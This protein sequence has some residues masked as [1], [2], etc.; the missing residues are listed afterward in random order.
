[1]PAAATAAAAAAATGAG[2]AAAGA[3]PRGRGR[4]PCVSGAAEEIPEVLWVL[5]SEIPH[6]EDGL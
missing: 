5:I 2:A 1:M 4:P 6:E 3:V